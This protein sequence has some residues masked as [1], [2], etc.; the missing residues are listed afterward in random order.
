MT[1]T[2]SARDRRDLRGRIPF[3]HFLLRGDLTPTLGEQMPAP[4]TIDDFLELVRK[5]NQVDPRR[6]D[7]YLERRRQDD[8]LPP[9]PKKFAALLVREGLLTNFQAEQFLQ[10]RYKGFNIGG[11]RILERIGSGGTGTVYLAEHEVMKRRVALKVVPPSISND[12]AILERFRREA[13]AAAVLDHPNIVRAYD[14]RQEG[15]LFI[16]VME[17]VNGPSLEQVLQTS[18]PLSVPIACDY[19]R[20]TALGLDHAHAQGLIHRDIKPGNLLVDPTGV[21]KIL[22]MGLARFSPDGQE[23]VTKKFDEH[24]VM[25][26]A[27]YLAP[28]QAINL[29]NV[30]LRAD[31]YSLGA[32]MYALLAGTPPFAEGTV[33]QKL[34]WHQMR[35]PVALQQR[36][37]DVP[38]EVAAVVAKMMAKAPSA[39]YSSCAEVAEALAPFCATLPTPQGP[40]RQTKSNGKPTSSYLPGTGPA[41]S[42]SS[43]RSSKSS[44][45]NLGSN[46]SSSSSARRKQASASSKSGKKIVPAPPVSPS[47]LRSR[48]DDDDDSPRR[49]PRPRPVQKSSGIMPILALVGVVFG[50]LAMVGGVIAFLVIGPTPPAPKVKN[51][52]DDEKRPPVVV[53]QQPQ[54]P[55]PPS[56]VQLQSLPEGVHFSLHLDRA[57]TKGVTHI[58]FATDGVRLASSG[59]DGSVKIWDLVGKKPLV[60]LSGHKGGT[61]WVDF[62][63][64]GQQLITAG[65]DNS[66]RTW[67]AAKGDLIKMY[68]HE[69][70]KVSCALYGL[71]TNELFTAAAE[72]VRWIDADSRKTLKPFFG[73]KEAVTALAYRGG[74]GHQLLSAS[75][76]RSIKH[77]DINEGREIRTLTGHTGIVS[78]ISVSADGKLMASGS[79]DG[80]VRL[81]DLEKGQTVHVFPN[82]GAVWA[83]A[84]SPDGRRLAAAGEN[85]QIRLWDLK[86]KHLEQVYAGH[87]NQVTSLC[88]PLSGRHLASGSLDSSIRVWGLPPL[89]NVP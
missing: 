46:S 27:D 5:S 4:D 72:I 33:T 87:T 70:A 34:L 81:W 62:S 56:T 77:W 30:D 9:D 11:Y 35:D 61:N 83:V 66:V 21:V 3:H 8:T 53:V 60:T 73:H 71:S 88:F 80:T 29:H 28:E 2:P 79:Y 52:D 19:I 43:H 14:F 25:G 45:S 84:L 15:Q 58:T 75:M 48:D 68:P 37:P 7:A 39:R 50:V 86:D 44:T 20:Q 67:N 51:E 55:P 57:H 17:F 54:Q 1:A 63:R 24:T 38:A 59:E 89:R 41:S 49:G 69:A 32:T 36:R 78:S 22:D 40:A 65:N 47:R 23:S 64:D 76:D 85:H 13:Q 6:L 12:P 10:G 18:G 74:G 31:I 82:L 16:L 42:T 26:T